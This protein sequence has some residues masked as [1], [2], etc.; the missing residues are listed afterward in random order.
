MKT[1]HSGATMSSPVHPSHLQ[2][3]VFSVPPFTLM[4]TKEKF[5]MWERFAQSFRSWVPSDITSLQQL[6]QCFS[7][8]FHE[9]HFPSP[10]SRVESPMVWSTE[11]KSQHSPMECKWRRKSIEKISLQA[12]TFLSCFER[13]SFN[14][15]FDLNLL[16]LG[17]L[18]CTLNQGEIS[19]HQSFLTKDLC[20][21]SLYFCLYLCHCPLLVYKYE[22]E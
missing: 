19:L 4:V 13:V 16:L 1:L 10:C 20:N 22:D 5:A 21:W 18:G 17:K 7:V 2:L 14:F 3:D 6:W 9:S 15:C 12:H 11:K 8:L